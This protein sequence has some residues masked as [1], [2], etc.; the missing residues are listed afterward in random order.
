MS[1]PPKR[2]KC[3]I[4][5][6]S[7]LQ[8]VQAWLDSASYLGR[9]SQISSNSQLFPSP[10]E[11]VWDFFLYFYFFMCVVMT[12]V[13]EREAQMLPQHFADS[14]KLFLL[15]ALADVSPQCFFFFHMDGD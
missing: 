14:A 11:D 5:A 7:R 3:S 2:D 15:I 9:F 12:S 8:G 10:K 6:L 13:W 4:P 1:F